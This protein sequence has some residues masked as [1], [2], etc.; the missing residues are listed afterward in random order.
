MP[1]GIISVG[2]VVRPVEAI[3]LGLFGALKSH[4][5]GFASLSTQ[6]LVA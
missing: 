4:G 2:G 6:C 5:F 1:H 3:L